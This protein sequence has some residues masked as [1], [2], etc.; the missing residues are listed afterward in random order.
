MPKMVEVEHLIPP[1]TTIAF[2]TAPLTPLKYYWKELILI[3]RTILLTDF[4]CKVMFFQVI[5]D[6]TCFKQRLTVWSQTFGCAIVAIA[7][8]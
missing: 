2:A 6:A 1:D 8:V 3:A 5:L 4:Y 7:T